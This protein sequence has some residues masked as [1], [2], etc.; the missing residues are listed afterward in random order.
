[1]L[2]NSPIKLGFFNFTLEQSLKVIVKDTLMVIFFASYIGM[3]LRHEFHEGF[4]SDKKQVI[5]PF[6]AAL[7]GIAMPAI[8]YFLININHSENYSGFAIPCATD[9]AFAICLFNLLGRSIPSSIKVFLL[10]IAIFDD[11]GAIII[12]AV[13]IPLVLKYS[14]YG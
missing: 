3:E 14:G 9:I 4:L 13:F 10:S 5:L 6:M 12:I 2:I 1:M 7:G 8:I 11:L